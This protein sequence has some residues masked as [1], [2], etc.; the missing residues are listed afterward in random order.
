GRKSGTSGKQWQRTTP[1]F[2]RGLFVAAVG[3]EPTCA[4]IWAAP[5]SHRFR[6]EVSLFVRVGITDQASVTLVARW[7]RGGHTAHHLPPQ[8]Y[9]KRTR[10]EDVLVEAGDEPRRIAIWPIPPR[11]GRVRTVQSDD[12]QRVNRRTEVRTRRV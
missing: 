6:V 1:C 2:C 9:W 4:G 7:T 8:N 3:F 5:G 10:V 12:H 11:G